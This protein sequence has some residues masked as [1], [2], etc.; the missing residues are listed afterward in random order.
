MEPDKGGEKRTI[1]RNMMFH[2]GDELPDAPD[3]GDVPKNS[4]RVSFKQKVVVQNDESEDS[5]ESDDERQLRQPRARRKTTFFNYAKLGQPSVNAL[6]TQRQSFY[7]P[8]KQHDQYQQWLQQ[9][10]TE[11]FITDMLL[12]N[13]QDP[14]RTYIS[15]SY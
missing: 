10:W 6:S 7:I 2:C 11:G 9:L 12:K 4:K 3:D 15:H 5:D 8:P 13:Q 14:L 1:H